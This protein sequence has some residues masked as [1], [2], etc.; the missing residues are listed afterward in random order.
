MKTMRDE[1][2]DRDYQAGRAELN[3]GIDRAIANIGKSLGDSLKLLHHIEWSAPWN[4][5]TNRRAGRA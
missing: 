1:L 2:F 4:A 5:K 3:A